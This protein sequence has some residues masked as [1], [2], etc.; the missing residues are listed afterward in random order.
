MLLQSTHLY[1]AAKGKKTKEAPCTARPAAAS[2]VVRGLWGFPTSRAGALRPAFLHQSIIGTDLGSVSLRIKFLL[3]GS[4]FHI[5]T[6]IPWDRC[7][8]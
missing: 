8:Q 2:P 3:I 5:L 7:T 6:C 4:E 1:N